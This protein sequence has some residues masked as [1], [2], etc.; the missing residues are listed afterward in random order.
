MSLVEQANEIINKL[1]L[2]EV[3]ARQ[4]QKIKREMSLVYDEAVVGAGIAEQMYNHIRA[5]KYISIKKATRQDGKRFTDN[6]ADRIAKQEA[7]DKYWNFR[8][9]KAKAMG[10]KA[11]I[12]A[13][14]GICLD[15]YSNR[16][17]EIIASQTTE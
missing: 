17:A 6:E 15:Y 4:L 14:E 9:L 7:E 3:G 13:I 11:K 2:E 12:Q 8:L 5:E 10:M 1:P 16:K